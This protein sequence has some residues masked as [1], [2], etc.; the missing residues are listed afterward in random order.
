M[1][2]L[3]VDG[4]HVPDQLVDQLAKGY[5]ALALEVTR[6]HEQ[7]QNLENKLAWAKQQASIP[8]YITFA[9]RIPI[10]LYCKCVEETTNSTIKNLTHHDPICSG[11]PRVLDA[12]GSSISTSSNDTA[13]RPPT[14]TFTIFSA[15]SKKPVLRR[16]RARRTG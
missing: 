11:D 6:I 8:R 14:P 7:R 3:D 4:P 9:M 13:P 12:N 15:S 10:A 16:R 1:S 2:A 5:D